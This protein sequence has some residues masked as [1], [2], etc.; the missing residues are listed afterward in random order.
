MITM[1]P[2][3]E[4]D[5]FVT[6]VPLG[7]TIMPFMT[8]MTNMIT[9]MSDMIMRSMDVDVTVIVVIVIA[10]AYQSTESVLQPCNI[11]LLHHL[12]T[13]T[14]VSRS[15]HSVFEDT[16]GECAQRLELLAGSRPSPSATALARAHGAPI[17][18]PHITQTIRP[19]SAGTASKH[20]AQGF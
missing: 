6:I 7:L 2:L 5:T 13:F 15:C 18:P 11:F 12:I 16:C 14:D 8:C 20:N 10:I 1:F 9:S 3:S 19:R 4:I 17:R